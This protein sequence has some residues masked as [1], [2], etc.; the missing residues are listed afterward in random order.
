MAAVQNTGLEFIDDMA[1]RLAYEMY[2]ESRW[3]ETET[4]L[5]GVLVSNPTDGWSL[6]VYASM[7]RKQG[8]FKEAIV[9]L[10]TA[11][12]L[13]PTDENIT[14]MHAEMNGFVKAIEQRRPGK[15]AKRVD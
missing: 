14:R 7:L 2:R 11:H 3:R 13:E 1:R 15:Q 4:L 5:K 10:E 6:S 8:K 9:L 12:A